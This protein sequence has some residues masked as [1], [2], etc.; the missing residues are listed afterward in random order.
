MDRIMLD[1]NEAIQL[2]K[3]YL[4]NE[5]L[6]Q[7]SLAVEVILRE[8]ARMMHENE[9]LWGLTGLL[10]DMDY[11]YTEEE[12]EKHTQLTTLLLEGLL[13]QEGIDAIQAH[14][15]THTGHLPVTALDRA[16][17]AADAVSG[18]VIATALVMPSK[19][20]AEVKPETLMNKFKDKSFAA[21]CD[22]KRIELCITRGCARTPS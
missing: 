1:R 4:K 18:L 21:R 17:V 10:H 20:L 2:L 5:K 12:P 3:K 15:Y 16:L 8:M 19:K 11:G 13:P 6:I 7:H 22:R 14:N 9:E